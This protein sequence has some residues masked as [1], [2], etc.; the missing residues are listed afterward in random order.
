MKYTFVR[1]N[2]ILNKILM[3]VFKKI[4]LVNLQT[5]KTKKTKFIKI[6][7]FILDFE[8]IMKRKTMFTTKTIQEAAIIKPMQT[9]TICLPML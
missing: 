5:F 7:N 1:K 9:L 2:L 4:V 8:E 6:S 3:T